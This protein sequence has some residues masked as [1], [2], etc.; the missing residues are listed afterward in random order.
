MTPD[1]IAAVCGVLV[2]AITAWTQTKRMGLVE[3]MARLEGRVDA[4]EKS[5]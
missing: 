5:R 4:L 3:R 1:I 2:A